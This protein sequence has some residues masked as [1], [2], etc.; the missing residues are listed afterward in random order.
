[1]REHISPIHRHFFASVETRTNF[2]GERRMTHLIREEI[3]DDLLSR[4]YSR[5]QMLRTAMMFG[6]GVAAASALT[7]NAELAFAADED[8]AGK[9]MVRIG[10]NECWTGPMAP[11]LAAG[12]AAFANANRYSP[13]GE[14]QKLV[15]AISAIE[16][17]PADHIATYPGSG[18]ILAR[19]L[20]AYCSPS[21]GLV[22]A[23]PT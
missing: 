9:G 8:D 5:R 6:G 20:V 7:F 4:G 22:Q 18:G 17:V 12:N 21:K 15:S 3:K 23:D 14:I 10:S 11:G 1:M 13:N 2:Q 16:N 19:T